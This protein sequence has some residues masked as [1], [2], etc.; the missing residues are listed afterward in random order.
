VLAE[1][2]RAA[3][4]P[5]VEADGDEST[6]TRV[7]AET[8]GVPS[9]AVPSV[10]ATFKA[11]CELSADPADSPIS[12]TARQRRVVVNH[13]SRLL[14][15]SIAEFETARLCLEHGLT[16][17]AVV[18]AWNSLAALAFAHLGDDDFAILR[19]SGRRAALDADD[20]MRKIDGAELIELLVVAE[21]IGADDRGVLERLLAQRDDCAHPVPPAP[22]REQ[23]AAYLN[24]V[25]AQASVLTQHPLA[26]QTPGQVSDS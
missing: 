14:Q 10:V 12:A 11:L 8:G 22:D 18:S 26:H 3:F 15:T 17:P 4:G 25:L 24:S 9:D 2:L 7:V 1:A 21:R 13:I 19:T 6:L 16:R 20:L 5:L 23:A